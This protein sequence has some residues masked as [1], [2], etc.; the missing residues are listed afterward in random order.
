MGGWKGMP[1]VHA[2]GKVEAHFVHSGFVFG[3]D[4]AFQEAGLVAG[5]IGVVLVALFS[6]STL[7]FL[8]RCVSG[9]E[10]KK[11][12]NVGSVRLHPLGFFFFL[13]ALLSILVSP[14]APSGF[15]LRAGVVRGM[16]E[17]A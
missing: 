10:R 16:Q 6:Y 5:V 9:K 12:G 4:R 1:V 2:H 15:C 14:L 3:S 8:I 13:T 17:E 7:R 11:A